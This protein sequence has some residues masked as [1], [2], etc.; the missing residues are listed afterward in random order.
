M[1]SRRFYISLF[2]ALVFVIFLLSHLVSP[3]IVH[4]LT[5]STNPITVTISN[6]P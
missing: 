6:V 2:I 3:G 1:L 4:G 5:I